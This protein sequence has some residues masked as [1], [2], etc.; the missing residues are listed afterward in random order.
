MGGSEEKTPE[1]SCEVC[2]DA[3]TPDGRRKARCAKEHWFSCASCG[4]SFLLKSTMKATKRFC[5]VKCA[6]VPN[7]VK[8]ICVVCGESNER[9]AKTCSTKCAT[10]LRNEIVSAQEKICEWCGVS[11][12]ALS[13]KKY[14]D[15]PHYSSC[16]VCESRFQVNPYSPRRTCSALCNGKLVNTPE[17]NEK[18]KETSRKNWGTD[19]P[20]Q[21][22]TVKA[23]IAASN[24]KRYG[25]KSPLASQELR[26]KGRETSLRNWGTE[27]HVQS[28]EGQAARIRTNLER[29]GVPNTFMVPEFIEKSRQI[30]DERISAGEIKPRKISKLNQRLAEMLE[31]ELNQIVTFEERFGKFNADLF[32]GDKVLVDLHPTV[33]HNSLKA[34]PCVIR[35]CDDGC[36][37]HQATSTVYHL[38]RAK[39]ALE[40]DRTLV[41]WYGWESDEAL[42]AYLK[43]K[44]EPVRKFSA[45]KLE[46]VKLKSKQANDFLAEHHIQGRGRGQSYFYGL[47]K[48]GELLAVATFGKSRF[49]SKVEWEFNRYAVKAG[50]VIHG[51]AGRLFDA[52]KEE[53]KP[54]SVVS[55][56]DFNHTTRQQTFLHSIRFEETG[57]TGP[58]LMWHRMKDNALV[59]NVSLLAQGADRL[60]GTNYGP[61]EECGLDNRDIML[62]EGFLPVYT[63]GN[64]VFVWGN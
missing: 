45:R 37:E 30:I 3:F 55:Y 60:L 8:R 28:P 20:F 16:D 2:G 32:V 24:V 21:A 7:K 61:K 34:F 5:S 40:A 35:G 11:F 62:V 10:K 22:E 9:R 46:L 47:Q 27:W 36:R 29:Y 50:V 23:K 41:Q 54:T 19:F 17:S 1:A 33:S 6:Q 4:D 26:A 58:A 31:S 53:A 42:V 56:L 39:A 51:A 12:S 57:F 43:R 63:A 64:R 48:D 13:T 25:A 38:N 49:G 15:G 44:F 52:F 59:N 14:C 18:R